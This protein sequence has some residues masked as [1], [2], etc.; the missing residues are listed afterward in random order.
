MPEL[1]NPVRT[2]LRPRDILACLR[3]KLWDESRREM[4]T[5]RD[6]A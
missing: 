1:Q 3:L 4:V 6:V 5:F 2:T